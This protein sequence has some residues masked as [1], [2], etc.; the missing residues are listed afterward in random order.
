MEPEPYCGGGTW[1]VTDTLPSGT[2]MYQLHTIGPTPMVKAS[3]TRAMV[4]K[5]PFRKVLHGGEK[6]S[7]DPTRPS[8]TFTFVEF[9]ISFPTGTCAHVSES[10]EEAS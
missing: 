1:K 7:I 6:S 4:P 10:S 9:V 2:E 5:E 8:V 3:P